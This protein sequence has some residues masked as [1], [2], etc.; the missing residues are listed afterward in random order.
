MSLRTCLLAMHLALLSA[1]TTAGFA[2]PVELIG[3]ITQVKG[4]VRL[5]GPGVGNVP[6]ASPWQAVRSGA[7]IRVPES[8]AAGI[9]CSTRHFIHLRGPV[10]WSLTGPACSAGKELTPAE[11]AL[12][13]PSNGRFKVVHGLWVL[14]REMRGDDGSDPV[15]PV[16]MSPRNTVLRV[17]RPAVSWLRVPLA[18]EYQVEWRGRGTSGYATRL[19]TSDATCAVRTDGLDIC[20]LPWPA[21]RS[22]LLPGETFFLRVAAR[23]GIV[24]P[25]HGNDPV[26]VRTQT[27]A[28]AGKLESRL[29]GLAALGLE[30]AALDTARAGVFAE[31]GLYDEA[32]D[33]YRRIL[34]TAPSPELRVTLADVE[35]ARSLHFLAEPLYR[36]VLADG[37]PIGRAA[38][39]FGLGRLLYSR[40][41]YETAAVA[42]R[43]A[44]E[45]YA[46]LKLTEET[47]AARRA[48]AKAAARIPK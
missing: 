25:W 21:G 26:E 10:S 15:A 45:F 18:T 4:S 42:F 37:P 17:A 5:A 7:I 39:A 19:D 14:D 33:S 40:G 2:K 47:A 43:Q 9:V 6:R 31:A 34:S 36:E 32:A 13:A 23:D 22:D 41:S 44:G 12:L 20:S 28:E 38:A 46:G 11:Y 30:G 29:G 24:K 16:V 8:G 27:V 35:L 3:V 1:L 48:A